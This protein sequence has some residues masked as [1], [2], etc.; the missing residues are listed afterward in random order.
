MPAHLLKLLDSKLASTAALV[1]PM[2]QLADLVVETL[3]FTIVGLL[4]FALAFWI[5]VKVSPFSI[6]KEIEEDQNM[7]LGI[8]IAAV[9]IGIALIVSAAVHG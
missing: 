2:N 9:I 6:R 4:L 5:I 8:V 7:A 3:A 1:V